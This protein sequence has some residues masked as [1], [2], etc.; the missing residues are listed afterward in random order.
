MWIMFNK[1]NRKRIAEENPGCTNVELS[2]LVSE[3]Y[4]QMPLEDR[5]ALRKDASEHR[6]VL[7]AQKQP[8]TTAPRNG[9]ILLSMEMSAKFQKENPDYSIQDR[10]SVASRMWRELPDEE[11][12]A[13]SARAKQMREEFA[14]RH[15]EQFMAMKQRAAARR[16]ESMMRR[17]AAKKRKMDLEDE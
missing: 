5:E 8:K 17:Y 9:Y 14:K 7:D 12:K 2:R 4:R 13:Y 6:K 3:A 15:P 11:K 10:N 1:A 16:S